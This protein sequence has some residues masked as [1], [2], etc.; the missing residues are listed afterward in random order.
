MGSRGKNSQHLKNISRLT[1]QKS[2]MYKNKISVNRKISG[3]FMRV[4][5]VFGVEL[6]N[7]LYVNKMFSHPSPPPTESIDLFLIATIKFNP[8]A[9]PTRGLGWV[10]SDT[11][12]NEWFCKG[13]L[14]CLCPCVPGE[15]L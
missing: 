14:H 10:N 8:K 11:L 9:N 7:F 13:I 1:L 5:T 2:R 15:F 12:C 4:L 3:V 6:C